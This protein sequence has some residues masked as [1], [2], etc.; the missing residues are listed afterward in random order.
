MF[1]FV[2]IFYI[3]ILYSVSCKAV[4][5]QCDSKMKCSI[6]HERATVGSS[7]GSLCYELDAERY[8]TLGNE[9]FTRLREKYPRAF[10][11]SIPLHVGWSPARSSSSSGDTDSIWSPWECNGDYDKAVVKEAGGILVPCS[12]LSV[13]ERL[14]HNCDCYKSAK[15]TGAE[16]LVAL[17]NLRSA[18]LTDSSSVIAEHDIVGSNH[19]GDGSIHDA[20]SYSSPA[21]SVSQNSSHESELIQDKPTEDGEETV[22]VSSVQSGECH[23]KTGINDITAGSVTN[24][25]HNILQMN[26]VDMD[27][28]AAASSLVQDDVERQLTHSDGMIQV[29]NDVSLPAEPRQTVSDQRLVTLFYT[30]MYLSSDM[31]L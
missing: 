30:C 24:T 26:S 25:D 20:A 19:S 7:S 27:H 4:Y 11:R 17:R 13:D 3:L 5:D 6:L 14:K 1:V 10:R 18:L 15:E 28:S 12:E 8:P 31:M 22:G 9:F 2:Y 23:L 29:S 16:L 21:N